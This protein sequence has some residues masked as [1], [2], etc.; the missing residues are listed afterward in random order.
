M[1]LKNCDL[2]FR[3]GTNYWYSTFGFN[4][5]GAAIEGAT[6][7]P[8]EVYVD[9]NI[10]DKVNM[11]SMTSYSNDPG[12][13]TKDCNT[14]IKSVTEGGV[15]WKLPG[16]GWASNINDMT[17]FLKGM[18]NGTFLKNTA[19]LWTDVPGNDSYCYGI[20]K[21]SRGDKTHVHHGGAHDDVRTYLGFFPGDKTGVC[22]MI[23]H[24]DSVNAERLGK[25]IEN[26]FGY[27]WPVDG[28]P[29][30]YSPIDYSGSNDDCGQTMF[31]V[32]RNTGKADDIVIRRGYTSQEFDA[33]Y[34]LLLDA[35]YYADDIETW[36]DGLVRKWDG[37]FKKTTRKS[38]MVP[39]SKI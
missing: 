9:D 18:I 35:G 8:Y 5:L 29:V 12:G 34:E 32:W 38:G 21:E 11:S 22:L 23:N 28:K 26:A 17:D 36:M 31:G 14:F 20:Q 7:K 25:L 39:R 2:A 24:G 1:F 30:S 16:G 27:A 19:A 3:P 37:I 15:E 4:L 33:E 10:S 13:F 6:G